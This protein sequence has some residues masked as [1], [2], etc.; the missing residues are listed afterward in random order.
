MFPFTTLI[1]SQVENLEIL[2][3][4]EH[5]TLLTSFLY[6]QGDII[7]VIENDRRGFASTQ[8]KIVKGDESPFDILNSELKYRTDSKWFYDSN[9]KLRLFLY[10]LRNAGFDD[11]S[12]DFI[13]IK[14]SGDSYEATQISNPFMDSVNGITGIAIDS[15]DYVYIL[16][17][18]PR[19]QLFSN[20]N[21]RSEI[22][23]DL[24]SDYVLHSNSNGNVYVLDSGK[25]TIYQVTDLVIDPVKN[26][27]LNV[28]DIKQVLSENWI[29]D[30]NNKVYAFDSEFKTQPKEIIFP[31][32]LNSLA[33]IS[34]FD[35]TIYAL[36]TNSAGFNLYQYENGLFS[37]IKSVDEDF[38]S[39]SKLQMI[40]DSIFL[41]AGQ[42][43]IEDIS[44]QAFIR[45]YDMN[46]LFTPDRKEV[47]MEYFNLT[48]LKDTVIQG[49]PNDLWIYKADASIL[50]H[51]S[52]NTNC[53]SIYTSD[54]VPQFTAGHLIYEHHIKSEI[55]SNDKFLIDTTRLIIF[56][57]PTDAIVTIPGSH[58]KFNTRSE[59]IPINITTSS[60]YLS[61]E[62]E[63]NIYPNPFQSE[64]N[65]SNLNYDEEFFLYNAYGELILRGVASE[66][67]SSVLESLKE[68]VYYIKITGQPNI[69]KL[70]KGK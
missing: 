33:Q 58:Y 44:N 59:A 8:V 1:F 2:D 25:D 50:N 51:D 39:S 65:F 28:E 12:A 46:Q 64:L 18:H 22:F 61:K 43:E 30:E 6:N 69:F 27:D 40:N 60:Y 55:L 32:Q 37:L 26:I 9:G 19:L 11:F 63:I 70:I 57:H 56:E 66:V 3:H 52:E 38:E 15:S 42:F 41:T 35:S 67:R 53:T 24:S 5:R 62:D 49:A 17:N 20:T 10:N 34:E 54:L 45:G 21:L 48:Y 16:T 13:E 7:Y 36:E 47:E 29:L 23:P 14:E 4:S 68:G 31:F